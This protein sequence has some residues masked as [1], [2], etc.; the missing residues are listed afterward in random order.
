MIQA[1]YNAK[2]QLEYLKSLPRDCPLTDELNL[3][4]AFAIGPRVV[5]YYNFI[6]GKQQ[7][8]HA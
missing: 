7:H 1:A 5:A 3:P 2:D 6:K 8:E 4:V